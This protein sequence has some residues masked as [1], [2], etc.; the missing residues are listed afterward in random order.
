ME[1]GRSGFMGGRLFPTEYNTNGDDKLEEVETGELPGYAV[2]MVGASTKNTSGEGGNTVTGVEFEI[3][4]GTEFET[5]EIVD[6]GCE[7]KEE[8]YSVNGL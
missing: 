2:T 8:P 4:M 7:V 6:V 5:V 1:D 3:V